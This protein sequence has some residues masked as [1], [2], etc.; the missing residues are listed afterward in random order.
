MGRWL[1]GRDGA[2]PGLPIA[3]LLAP[4][5]LGALIVLVANDW[6]WKPSGAVPGWLTGKLSDVAGVIVLPLVL[7][8]A[9]ALGLRGLA[10][11]GLGVDWT[12]RRWKLAVAIAITATLMV[13]TK[14]SSG[15]AA[16][17]AGLLG[18]RARI[19]TDPTDL[20]AL[21]AL[22]L[23]WWHGRRTI[24]RVPYGRI[25]WIA[26]RDREAHAELADVVGCGA[27]PTR[28]AALADAI[29]RWRAGSPADAVD[30]AVDALRR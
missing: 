3:E 16:E 2:R 10:W 25:A 11:A 5:P 26:A 19:V 30:A 28:V 24:A 14:L 6:W 21:P 8:A 7:T 20:V 13:A 22:A 9:L 17:V 18:D 27:D 12:L 29:D 1:A 4:L 23:V 15:A